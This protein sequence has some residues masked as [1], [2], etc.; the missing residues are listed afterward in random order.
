MILAYGNAKGK[1]SKYFVDE[2]IF[3]SSLKVIQTNAK[4]LGIEVI[5]T[6]VENLTSEEVSDACGIHMQSPDN[7]GRL[8]DW[9]ETISRLKEANNKITASVGTDMASL[10]LFKSP[11]KMGADVAYGNSQRFGVPMGYGGPAA[12]FFCTFK[13][14]IR[15]LPGRIIGVSQ[16]RHGE[17]AYR[18]AL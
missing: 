8:R 5:V 9:T 12:A 7:L 2:N 13:K 16:D 14:N 6:D 17:S 4:Y 3:P 10:M 15:K 1:A 18:M 11:G